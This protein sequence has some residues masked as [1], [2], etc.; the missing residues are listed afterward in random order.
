[1]SALGQKRTK[2]VLPNEVRYSPASGPR[3]T[4]GRPDACCEDHGH[5]SEETMRPSGVRITAAR[6]SR[7]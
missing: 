5:E 2:R 4:G 3:L 6:V 1:M 7:A